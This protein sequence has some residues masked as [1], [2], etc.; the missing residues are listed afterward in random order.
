[1]IE[2]L[3]DARKLAHGTYA[4]VIVVEHR[5]RPGAASTGA[6]PGVQQANAPTPHVVLEMAEGTRVIDKGQQYDIDGVVGATAPTVG[7]SYR[8]IVGPTTETAS[9]GTTSGG[10]LRYETTNR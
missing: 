6:L 2:E 7:V 1:M 9:S 10:S 4:D 3:E 8:L 5:K